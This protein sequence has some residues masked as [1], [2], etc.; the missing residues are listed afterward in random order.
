MSVTYIKGQFCV[1]HKAFFREYLLIFLSHS[2]LAIR[3]YFCSASCDVL[4]NFGGPGGNKF[5]F[6][7]I[8]LWFR[9]EGGREGK[10]GR[11]SGFR[12]RKVRRNIR[13][14]MIRIR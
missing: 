7:F 14:R 6:S 1:Y 10:G 4:S 5:L 2:F 11:S 8:C 3:S 12:K 13:M 9:P